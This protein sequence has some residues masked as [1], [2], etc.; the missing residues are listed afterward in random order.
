MVRLLVAKDPAIC[1]ICLIDKNGMSG[2]HRA[3]VNNQRDIVALLLD[4]VSINIYLFKNI[5]VCSKKSKIY[6]Y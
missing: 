2:L 3:A 4:H 6:I 1:R 5:N